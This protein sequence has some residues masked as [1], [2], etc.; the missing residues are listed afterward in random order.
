MYAQNP[1]NS[2]SI[3]IYVSFLRVPNYAFLLSPGKGLT[4]VFQPLQVDGTPST[5][6]GQIRSLVL[7]TKVGTIFL[8]DASFFFSFVYFLGSLSLNVN[9]HIFTLFVLR[10][11]WF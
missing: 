2:R 3:N 8:Y 1:N 5:G 10:N 9:V 11:M 7:V 4:G 6:D